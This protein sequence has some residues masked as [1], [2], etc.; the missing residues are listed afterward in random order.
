M[1]MELFKIYCSSYCVNNG[2]ELSVIVNTE[3]SRITYFNYMTD[4]HLVKA[5]EKSSKDFFRRTHIINLLSRYVDT[6]LNSINN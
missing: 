4:I 1:I 3:N 6:M 2:T 5:S